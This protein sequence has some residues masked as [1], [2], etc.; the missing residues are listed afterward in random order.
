MDLYRRYTRFFIED[1]EMIEK[2]R[3]EIERV[4]ATHAVAEFWIDTLFY[5]VD[6]RNSENLHRIQER[7]TGSHNEVNWEIIKDIL[8]AADVNKIKRVAKP[9][10]PIVPPKDPCSNHYPKQD[11]A[12]YKRS[13]RFGL[14]L[15]IIRQIYQNAEY[16]ILQKLYYTCKY[17]FAVRPEIICHRLFMTVHFQNGSKFIDQS[18]YVTRGFTQYH[19][20]KGMIITEGIEGH[21]DSF[22][23]ARLM[24][25]KFKNLRPAWE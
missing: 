14:P 5:E 23:S 8:E 11:I 7:A 12:I 13:P 6:F 19:L 18:L 24:R 9:Q 15:P 3:D 17:F 10:K 21:S 4:G 1:L 20:F 25:K 2:Y 16:E 22:E